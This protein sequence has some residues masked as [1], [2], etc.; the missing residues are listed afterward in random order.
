MLP[1]LIFANE[2]DEHSLREAVDYLKSQ[3]P[4]TPEEEAK[5]IP[6]GKQPIFYNRV[7]WARTYLKQAGLLCPTRRNYLKIT[8]RGKEVLQE[9]P[10]KIDMKYL[11]KFSEYLDF[12]ERTKEPQHETEDREK[13][14]LVPEELLDDAYRKLREDLARELLDNI[15]RSSSSFFERLVVELLI[16]IGYGGSDINAARVIGQSGDEGI[17][18][19]IDEDKL[20]L[21]SIYIQAKK[22]TDQ[23][24]GRPEI[25]KFV[26][27]LQGKRAQKGIFIT[28]SRFTEQAKDYAHNIDTRVVLIDGKRLTDL[29]IDYNVGVSSTITY[30]VKRIDTDYFIETLE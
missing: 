4:L 17:D 15:I 25:Q 24:I 14:S 1:V 3:F 21:D 7:G 27:A 5:T 20:G 30:Q 18:G 22:W 29:M 23:P 12:R 8:D 10:S 2:H 26:G 11:E 19:I 13:S 6:S 9:N 16:N 28:A